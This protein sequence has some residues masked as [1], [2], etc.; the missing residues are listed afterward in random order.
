MM[1]TILTTA[2]FLSNTGNLDRTQPDMTGRE[3]PQ[4]G[5]SPVGLPWQQQ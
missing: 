3:G 5:A 1:K 4:M 2:P